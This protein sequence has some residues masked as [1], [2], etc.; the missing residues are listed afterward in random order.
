M[1]DIPDDNNNIHHSPYNNIYHLFTASEES[2][3][4]TYNREEEPLPISVLLNYNSSHQYYWSCWLRL[5]GLIVQH[6]EN[7]Q[8]FILCISVIHTSFQHFKLM[9]DQGTE[10]I[11]QAL[12]AAIDSLDQ[13]PVFPFS[14]RQND[15][16]SKSN[17]HWIEV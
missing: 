9:T 1:D 14:D 13:V 15:S 3:S 17:I 10:R 4:L 16:Q 12:I 5:L 6:L 2:K 11:A 7:C 8:L